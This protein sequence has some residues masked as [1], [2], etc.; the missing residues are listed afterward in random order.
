MNFVMNQCPWRRIDRSTCWPV[1]Q[2][3]TTVPRMPLNG[4]GERGAQTQVDCN[5][6]T[7]E[8]RAQKGEKADEESWIEKESK[9]RDFLKPVT[10]MVVA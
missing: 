4:V 3:A 9:G 10:Y 6:F 8:K 1:V 2:R 7:R 5:I